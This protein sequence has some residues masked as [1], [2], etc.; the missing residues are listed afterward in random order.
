MNVKLLK[1]FFAIG[2]S[3]I[4]CQATAAPVTL[5]FDAT[6]TAPTYTEKGLTIT[7]TGDNTD[8]AVFSGGWGLF[9]SL[10]ATAPAYSLTTGG[11]FD[12]ISV[13]IYHSDLDDPI[14]FNGFKNSILKATHTVNANDFG[15]LSF[16]GFTSLDEVTISVT[17]TFVDPDFDNLTFQVVPIP[18]ALWL[19]GGAL[20]GLR[21]V[22]KR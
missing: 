3:W 4:S 19:F 13:D 5:T 11:L 1:I 15:F 18:A 21:R 8:V 17:G 20:L 22:V 9:G 10:G 16:A 12:L 7:A 6:V 14:V 2:L